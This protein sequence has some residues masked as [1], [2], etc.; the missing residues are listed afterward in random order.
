MDKDVTPESCVC[1]EGGDCVDPIFE[2][3]Y[4]FVL[5]LVTCL[6]PFKNVHILFK[7]LSFVKI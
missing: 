5:E 7:Y 2:E 6:V 4:V 3:V 1:V